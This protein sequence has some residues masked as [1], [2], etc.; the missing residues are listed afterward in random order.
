MFGRIMR[1]IVHSFRDP[2]HRFLPI[3]A[4]HFVMFVDAKETEKPL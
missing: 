4:S 1:V 3:N 2:I